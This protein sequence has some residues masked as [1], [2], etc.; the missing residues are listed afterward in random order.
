MVCKRVGIVASNVD[1][2]IETLRLREV[3]IVPK[4]QVEAAA[5]GLHSQLATLSKTF[6]AACSTARV[7]SH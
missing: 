2:V 6:V 7:G 1:L 5:R 4:I 3:L